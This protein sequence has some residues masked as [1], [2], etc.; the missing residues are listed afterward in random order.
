MIKFLTNMF[1]RKETLLVG[2]VTMHYKTKLIWMN[3]WN[4]DRATYRCYEREDGKRH[5]EVYLTS[6]S[7]DASRIKA[8]CTAGNLY[9][10]SM[11]K[12]HIL[13]MPTYQDIKS[14]AKDV[15]EYQTAS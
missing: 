11:R 13:A 7:G 6:G 4:N 5:L 1:R 9:D 12:A 2:I 15:W 14:G 8:F 10:W 3:E